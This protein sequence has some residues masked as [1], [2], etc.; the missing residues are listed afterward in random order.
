MSSSPF[1]MTELLSGKAKQQT[2][3][4]TFKKHIWTD[5]LPMCVYKR[6]CLCHLNIAKLSHWGWRPHTPNLQPQN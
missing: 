3:K 1:G 6:H 4:H 5:S 2:M